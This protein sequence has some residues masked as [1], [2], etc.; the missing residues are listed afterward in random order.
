MAAHVRK[1][2]AWLSHVDQQIFSCE[3][4][5]I[6]P[7]AAIYRHSLSLLKT[8]PSQTIFVDD[9]EA[10]VHAAR[11]EGIHGILFESVAQFR[12]DLQQLGFPILPGSGADG[13]NRTGR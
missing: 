12:K 6:K 9:R 3:L 11:A 2:F 13:H 7:D 1:N 10:N 5:A 4:R 8:A